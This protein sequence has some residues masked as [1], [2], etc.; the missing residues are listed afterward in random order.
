MIKLSK[1]A[2]YAVVI[3]SSMVEEG[4]FVSA[5][6]LSDKTDIAEP[7]VAK[8]L[9]LLS[10]GE[11]VQS[12]RGAQGGYKLSKE[13]KDITVACIVSAV[14]GPVAL[15]ACVENSGSCCDLEDTC[16][17]KGK[18]DPVNAAMVQAL[19]SVNLETMIGKQI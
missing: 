19:S 10:K 12:A 3:L 2:D 17:F 5:A 13:P 15:T 16:S 4:G 8:V 14:D 18:W 1:M 6:Y 9:K 7:T 11:I